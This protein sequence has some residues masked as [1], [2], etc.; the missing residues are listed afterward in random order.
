MTAAQLGIPIAD[1]G[2]AQYAMHSIR[3]M[4]GT[5][6]HDHMTEAMKAFLSA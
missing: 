6:D 2:S 1:V 3:E 4:A 5:W